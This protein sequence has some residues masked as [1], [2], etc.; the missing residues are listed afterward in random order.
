MYGEDIDLSYRII[1]V[2]IKIIISAI[3]LS[4]TLKVKA[5]KTIK[6]IAKIFMGQ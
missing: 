1:K 5:Q 2:V 4:F 6:L 3:T